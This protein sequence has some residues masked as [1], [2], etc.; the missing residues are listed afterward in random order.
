VSLF[1]CLFVSFFVLFFV[2]PFPCS[3]TGYFVCLV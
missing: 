1:P 2:R 3:D